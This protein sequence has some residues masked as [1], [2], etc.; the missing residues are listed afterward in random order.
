MQYFNA[1]LRNPLYSSPER[2]MHNAGVCSRKA[3]DLQT[4][5]SQYR[6]ALQRQPL[7]APSLLELSDLTFAQGRVKEAEALLIRHMQVMQAS[8]ADALL[9]GIRI[10]RAN[11]DKTAETS[12]VQQLRR[13]FPDSPQAR[14]VSDTR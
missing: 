7:Y 4:A 10:A 6:A 8:S 12:Y 9:L 13:R 3:G 11:G 5:E 2:A 1:A 14:A